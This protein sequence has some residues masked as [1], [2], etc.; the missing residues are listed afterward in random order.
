MFTPEEQQ[1][2]ICLLKSNLERIGDDLVVQNSALPALDAENEQKYRETM[3]ALRIA[4]SLNAEKERLN[5]ENVRLT[6][7]RTQLKR[8]CHDATFS[9]EKARQYRGELVDHLKGVEQEAEL[10]IRKY[11]DSLRE[12]ADRFR[13]TR[14]YYNEE[15][16]QKE[17]NTVNNVVLELENEKK[18][19]ESAV[20]EL[21]R[22]LKTLQPSVPAKLLDILGK[23]DLEET[24]KIISEK[25]KDLDAQ[26]KCLGS[27]V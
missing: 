11:E 13:R 23:T 22:Q 9:L 18:N 1:I 17:I 26:R 19:L 25:H 15:E 27:Y 7:K 14:N 16:T 20:E 2:E 8:Q 10:L 4:R 6:A 3:T 5:Q 21:I 12:K 24:V